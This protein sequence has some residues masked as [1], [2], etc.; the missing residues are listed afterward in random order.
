MRSRAVADDPRL[1]YDASIVRGSCVLALAAL[2]CVV[3]TAAAPGAAEPASAPQTTAAHADE[4]ARHQV[5][6]QRYCLTCHTE[7][8][9]DQGLAPIALEGLD[10]ADVGSHAETW[11]AVVRKLRLG[12]MPPAGRPRPDAEANGRFVTWLEAS[13]DAAAAAAPYPGRPGVRRLT[14]AEYVNAIGHLLDM[15][16]DERWLLFPADDVNQQGFSTSADVLSISPAL[17]ERYLAAANRISRLAVGDP[18]IGPGYVAATYSTPRLLYQDDRASEDLPFGS[19]GGMAIKHYFPLDGDY[20]VKI[21]LRRMIYD[22]IVGMGRSHV[23]EVRLDGALIERFTVGDADRFGYPSAYSFFGTIR[24]DPAW[25]EYVSNEADAG[26][27]VRFPAKA[28]LRTVGVSFVEA[29]TEPTGVLERRLSGFSLS[30]L[31]FYHGNAAVERVE[32]AGPYDATGPGD[33]PSRRRLF[34]CRPASGDVADEA[35]CATEILT[36]LARRAYRR[37]V[38]DGD[39]ATLMEFYEAGHA[40]RDFE[41]GIQK[42]V[43]RM[44]VAPQFL[45][46]IERD[47]VDIRAGAAYRLTDLELASRLS[48][49][50]WSSIPDDELLD[51]AEAGRLSDPDVL[52]QQVRRMLADRRASAL[53]ENFASQWLQLP[54]IEGVT[55]DA[56]VF[57]EFDEN[58][59]ADM[60]RETKLFLE[61][62]VRGD[63]GLRELLTADYTFVN[64]RLAR[65]YGIPGVYGERF[66]R[67]A[68]D[69]ERRGGLLGHASLLTLTAYPT[70]TSPVLRGK[71]VLDNILGSP[72]PEA[73]P[74][75]PALEENHGGREVLSMRE[76]MEQHRANPACAS[77]H[78]IMD[79]PGFVL[80]NYDAIGRWR[81]AD[82][83]G[84]PVETSGAL[85]DGTVVGTP[86]GFRDALLAY[87]VS[88]VRTVTEKLLGYAVGRTMEHT[89]QP[90]I[91]QVVTDAAAEDYRWSSIVLGIVNS[92][93]F[94]MR[95]AEP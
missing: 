7:A 18:T 72:P 44:L 86:R 41:A 79:P 77:C 49:F 9:R 34:T 5:L 91:R 70:R 95:S 76:R 3:A 51:L 52:E 93:P 90:A 8:R 75:V 50:L 71:W 31:G 2:A 43:E 48:F 88:F 11:E 22:Y 33:T 57:Y 15:D 65:H 64:E 84:A 1:G 83:A 74:N 94:Q 30:G 45:F 26:L 55:P 23:I 40:E 87:D 28:G 78:R 61:S 21:R 12:M 32:I 38:T 16:V 10:L 68:V 54:R 25:E 47:P 29:R 17:F 62:Q 89:D 4:A 85:A 20:E 14:T 36:A 63:R 56:D 37:P 60:E 53:V 46:R 13:L 19:R 27:A 6:V 35:R 24:G 81:D 39:L 73:P 42:A 82:E 59:R 58:L 80:E 66:R 69:P 67:V 92:T